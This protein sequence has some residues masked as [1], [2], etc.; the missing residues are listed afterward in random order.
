[1]SILRYN[2]FNDTLKLKNLT[3]RMKVLTLRNL[4]HKTKK[5]IN[6]KNPIPDRQNQL[7]RNRKA[8]KDDEMKNEFVP[9]TRIIEVTV[10]HGAARDDDAMMFSHL[11]R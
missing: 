10:D 3:T 8:R 6:L 7:A 4:R 5:R 11:R 1:M 2:I 9:G